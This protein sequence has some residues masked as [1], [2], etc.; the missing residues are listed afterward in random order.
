M[1]STI[2]HAN[3]MAWKVP[4]GKLINLKCGL[5]KSIIKSMKMKAACGERGVGISLR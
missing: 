3:K 1:C 5:R 2:L 4:G